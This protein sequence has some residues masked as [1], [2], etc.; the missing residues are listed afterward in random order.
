MDSSMAKVISMKINI[1]ILGFIIL[2]TFLW[3]SQSEKFLPTQ[4]TKLK[5]APDFS[6]QKLNGDTAKLRDHE[7]KVI[8]LHFWASWCAPCL[9]E[10]PD[11]IKLAASQPDDFILL[12]IST[13][14]KKEN[15]QNFLK[16]L[17]EPFTDNFIIGQDPDQKIS[18]DLYG[19]IKLPESYLI[20]ANMK[21]SEKITGAQENWNDKRWHRK[22][23]KLFSTNTSE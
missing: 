5:P 18:E 8:L 21:I 10:F 7:G 6:Y 9:V 14:D 22:I 3:T 19:T 12:A 17:K 4:I 13:D 20:T 1:L 15:I 16:K 23:R 2:G 11:L